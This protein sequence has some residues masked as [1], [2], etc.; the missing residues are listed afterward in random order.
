MRVNIFT[1]LYIV[2][3]LLFSGACTKKVS[4][5]RSSV[6]PAAEA[7]VK[8]KKDRNGNYELAINVQNLA[9]PRNLSPSRETY[10]VW[11]R[12]SDHSTYNLGELRVGNNLKGSLTAVTP[13]EPARL[14]IT[15]ENSAA[16]RYPSNQEVLVTNEFRR[17]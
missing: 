10:V 7:L 16:E 17:R 11:M 3:V 5:Q 8:V 4:F 13:H 12:S 6:V 1:F 15:A 9:Q 14:F 2:A